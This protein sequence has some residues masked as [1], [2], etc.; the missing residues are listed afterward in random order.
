VKRWVT[1]T[2]LVVFGIPTLWVAG[3]VAGIFWAMQ[4]SFNQAETLKSSCKNQKFLLQR[5]SLSPKCV[6]QDKAL[7]IIVSQISFRI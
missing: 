2:F 1:I 5:L 3:H 6:K 7:N 4:Q